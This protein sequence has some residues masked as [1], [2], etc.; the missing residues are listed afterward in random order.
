MCSS[1]CCLSATS[2]SESASEL[3]KYRIRRSDDDTLLAIAES[4]WIY[5][6]RKHGVPRRI[7][8]ELKDSFEPTAGFAQDASEQRT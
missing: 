3:R 8:Q 5:I 4:N 2:G 6:D 1:L 7:S